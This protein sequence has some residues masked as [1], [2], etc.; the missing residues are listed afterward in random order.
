MLTEYLSPLDSAAHDQFSRD[1]LPP[2]QHFIA[3][4]CIFACI[5]L[6]PCTGNVS[7]FT[8]VLLITCQC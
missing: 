1:Q 8:H 2:D 3:E 7:L 4:L 5:S 6:S